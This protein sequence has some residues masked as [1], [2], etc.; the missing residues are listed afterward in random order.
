VKPYK[1]DVVAG[2]GLGIYQDVYRAGGGCHISYLEKV[3]KKKKFRDRVYLWMERE[4]YKKENYRKI[5]ANSNMVK[6]EL[7]EYYNVP[8]EDIVVI[9]NGVDLQAFHPSN[10]EKYN[11][12]LREEFNVPKDDILILYV[13]SGYR[14]KGVEFIIRSAELVKKK[15]PR[16]CKYLIVGREKYRKRY[17]RL[18]LELGVEEDI[19][20]A[21]K[22]SNIEKFYGAADIFL[23]P[24]LYDPFPNVCLEAMA[25]GVPVITSKFAGA[26]E[27]MKDCKD[28]II[29]E[30]PR[31]VEEIANKTLELF[32]DERRFV[33]GREARR[34]AEKYRIEDTCSKILSVYEEVVRVKEKN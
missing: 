32:D 29:L 13:G 6:Q 33:L 21:G 3:K 27:I 20:F 30:N 10:R 14:R 25:S 17:E 5:I 34:V 24:T 11:E 23:F 18:A 7:M 2:F 22:Q 12:E 8:D 19:I 15:K 16:G 1:F 4:R 28:G 9:Y 31:D 26:S